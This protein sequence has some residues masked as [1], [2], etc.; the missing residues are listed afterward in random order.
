MQQLFTTC[1]LQNEP[2]LVELKRK[3]GQQQVAYLLSAINAKTQH[4]YWLSRH[5]ILRMETKD[6][7]DKALKIGAKKVNI[8]MQV[9]DLL[10]EECIKC[11][12]FS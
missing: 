11:K 9:I 10:D 5:C 3:V 6:D 7:L 8:L 2:F 12:L 4:D 1:L